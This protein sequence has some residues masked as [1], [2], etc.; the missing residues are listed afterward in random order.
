MDL[1]VRACYVLH[2][3]PIVTPKIL[4]I[5]WIRLPW[6]YNSSMSSILLFHSAISRLSSW[7][8]LYRYL[9]LSM[10][11]IL[12]KYL[13]MCLVIIVKFSTKSSVLL[14]RAHKI[15]IALGRDSSFT[16]IV[17]HY[18]CGSGYFPKFSERLILRIPVNKSFCNLWSI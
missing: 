2:L 8:A 13:N 14:N 9:Y 18:G 4:K 7:N 11:G 15:H 6:L 17:L 12:C 3:C 10:K 16:N 1:H 5:F